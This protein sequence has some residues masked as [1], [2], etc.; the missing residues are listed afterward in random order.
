MRKRDRRADRMAGI[1]DRLRSSEPHRFDLCP[2]CPN[3][4]PDGPGVCSIECGPHGNGPC[5]CA[6]CLLEV[7][8]A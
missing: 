6:A 1:N 2:G 3:R 7:T 4:P 5:R 8:T